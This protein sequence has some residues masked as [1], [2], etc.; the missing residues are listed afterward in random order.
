MPM[1]H[2]SRNLTVTAILKLLAHTFNVTSYL[3]LVTT[4]TE[5]K[6]AITSYLSTLLSKTTTLPAKEHE[7]DDNT[8]NSGNSPGKLANT[9]LKIAETTDSLLIT[10]TT[11]TLKGY[12][13]KAA[14]HMEASSILSN[15]TAT[16]PT[17]STSTAAQTIFCSWWPLICQVL[18]QSEPSSPIEPSK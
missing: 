3:L 5:G 1:T 2:Y 17:P 13:A 4:T 16:S 8:T 14:R 6:P 9:I 12:L 15:V 7:T 10:Q 11:K 18:Y